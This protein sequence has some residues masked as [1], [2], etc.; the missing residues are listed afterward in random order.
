VLFSLGALR[1]AG[2]APRFAPPG[3]EGSGLI[4]LRMLVRSMA[5]P[6]TPSAG[7]SEVAHL[8]T[9]GLFAAPLGADDPPATA[10]AGGLR[11]PRPW[12]RAVVGLALALATAA[13]VARYALRAGA[14][15]PGPDPVV[16]AARL[17]VPTV[18]AAAPPAPSPGTSSARFERAPGRSP[19][20]LAAVP[21][22]GRPAAPAPATAPATP[23]APRQA[24]GPV[25]PAFDPQA[26]AVALGTADVA[27]CVPPGGGITAGHARL[28]LQPAGIVSDAEVDTPGF[29]GTSAATCVA[30]A[31][32]RVKVGAFAGPART[33]GKRFTVGGS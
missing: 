19:A 30:A 9:G 4:D 13:V 11:G 7:A 32:R 28:T 1:D 3:A 17:E 26:V 31:Y 2:P 6:A 25:G 21:P 15:R 8:G 33:V 10:V 23:T 18:V 16:A 22:T 20:P 5:T 29:A 12:P 27:S 24:L 14:G